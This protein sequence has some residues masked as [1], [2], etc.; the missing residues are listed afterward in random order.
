M[1]KKKKSVACIVVI[2][3]AR[4]T[5][6]CQFSGWIRLS[7]ANIHIHIFRYDTSALSKI[8]RRPAPESR[9][10]RSYCYKFCRSNR[11]YQRNATVDWLRKLN[12]ICRF[13]TV[14]MIYSIPLDFCWQS[15]LSRQTMARLWPNLPANLLLNILHAGYSISRFTLIYIGWNSSGEIDILSSLISNLPTNLHTYIYV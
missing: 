12:R 15:L 3:K 5:A 9:F 10:L 13:L 6:N 4:A 2:S 11:I 8:S 14:W 1:N 7:G